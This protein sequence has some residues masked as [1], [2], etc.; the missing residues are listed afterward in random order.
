MVMVVNGSVLFGPR[1][2]RYP[3]H[4][5][6]Q[7]WTLS[8]LV[9]APKENTKPCSDRPGSWK[10]TDLDGGPDAGPTNCGFVKVRRLRFPA[11]SPQKLLQVAQGLWLL[12]PLLGQFGES[13]LLGLTDESQLNSYL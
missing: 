4:E 6:L 1:D 9:K 5:D 13:L 12:L 10:R 2:V 3:K 8:D 11:I 7:A